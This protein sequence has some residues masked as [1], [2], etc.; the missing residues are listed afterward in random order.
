MKLKALFPLYLAVVFAVPGA[1]IY[2]HETIL[3]TGEPYLF[4]TRPVDPYDLFRGRY[5]SLAFEQDTFDYKGSEYFDAK[6]KVYAV[7]GQ[8]AQGFASIASLTR[9]KPKDGAYLKVRVAWHE[10]SR[11]VYDE[12]TK[13]GEN[14]AVNT[15]HLLLPFNRFYMN[16]KK[17]PKAEDYYRRVHTEAQAKKTE[18]NLSAQVRVLKGHGILEALSADGKPIQERL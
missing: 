8:D 11:W 6:D 9:V 1:M 3:K 17:A 18:V 14:V 12:K 15:V 13:Q 7:L 4:K 10:T 2:C 5:V 16:E